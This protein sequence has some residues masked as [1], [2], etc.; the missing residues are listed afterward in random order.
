[1][2]QA[3]ALSRWPRTCWSAMKVG[4]A[5]FALRVS[6]ARTRDCCHHGRARVRRV[7]VVEPALRGRARALAKR[8]M[9]SSAA[10]PGVISRR[11]TM[12]AL[13]TTTETAMCRIIVTS[14]Q[15]GISRHRQARSQRARNAALLSIRQALAARNARNVSAPRASTVSTRCRV[16][17]VRA[18]QARTS[19]VQSLCAAPPCARSVH[20]ANTVRPA[21]Q[22]AFRVVQRESTL[23]H[24]LQAACRVLGVG[25]SQTLASP[26]RR[27][28]DARAGAQRA[29]LSR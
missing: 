10:P 29:L 11:M 18:R 8:T 1:M 25:T 13:M 17:V 3:R 7:L 15:R 9:R 27:A 19:Q 5:F 2:A 4:Y 24:R 28:R 20:R 6:S 14:A 16:G 26:A 12:T 22:H 21:P 23:M